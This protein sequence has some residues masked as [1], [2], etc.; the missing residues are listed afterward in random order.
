[1]IQICFT[2]DW[3]TP[4]F[5]W[6]DEEEQKPDEYPLHFRGYEYLTDEEAIKLLDDPNVTEQTKKAIKQIFD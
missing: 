6:Y 2:K 3:G 5:T 1:M 4:N